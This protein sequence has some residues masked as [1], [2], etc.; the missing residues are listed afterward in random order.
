VE[1]KPVDSVGKLLALLDDYRIGQ[2]ISLSV[3]R[4]EQAVDVVA[5]LQAGI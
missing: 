1:G 4:G 2:K 5:T 3:R